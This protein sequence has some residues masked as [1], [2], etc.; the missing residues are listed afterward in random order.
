MALNETQPNIALL[1]IITGS[2][3]LINLPL[4]YRST[5]EIIKAWSEGARVEKENPNLPGESPIGSTL[6]IPMQV[7]G[8]VIGVLNVEFESEKIPSGVGNLINQIASRLGLVLENARLVESAQQLVE[9][10]QLTAYISDEIRQSLDI[11][12]VVKT[13]TRTIAESLGLATVEV[14]L[15][16]LTATAQ[17]NGNRN[18]SPDPLPPTLSPPDTD[19]NTDLNDEDDIEEQE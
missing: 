12:T 2:S 14:Q 18:N 19:G 4:N 11:D 6:A 3:A 17:S 15:G 7:R 13:A 5:P 10:E 8:E 1:G 9:R 16:T